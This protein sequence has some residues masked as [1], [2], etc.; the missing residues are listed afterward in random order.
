MIYALFPCSA[1]A[2]FPG[3]LNTADSLR[4]KCYLASWHASGIVTGVFPRKKEIL[5]YRYFSRIPSIVVT[6]ERE[7]GIRRMQNYIFTAHF[8]VA[9]IGEMPLG[10]INGEITDVQLWGFIL[11][12]I[13]S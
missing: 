6:T 2:A 1:N 4:E 10:A 12:S 5:I 3:K 7:K 9:V 8:I 13:A 11:I